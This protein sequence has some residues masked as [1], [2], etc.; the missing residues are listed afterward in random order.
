MELKITCQA[1]DVLPIDKII[2]LQGALKDLTKENHKKLR[3][4]LERFG[5]NFPFF[6]WKQPSGEFRCLDGHQRLNALKQMRDE[7]WEIPP[8]PVSWIEADD[9]SD[10]KR[11]LLNVVSQYGE[12]TK[13]GFHDFFADT[14]FTW[15]DVISDLRMPELDF[16]EFA[17]EHEDKPIVDGEEIE[18]KQ[19]E[20]PKCGELFIAK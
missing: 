3:N 4:S 9:Y 12:V 14:N 8:L 20:C 18:Q 5:F 17:I 15:Q 19:I 1:A 7:G 16:G 11:R 13:Q 10:A 6:V 2:P